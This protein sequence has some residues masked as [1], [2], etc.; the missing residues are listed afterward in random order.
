MNILNTL[1]NF[2]YFP[3]ILNLARTQRKGMSFESYSHLNIS[4]KY[5]TFLVHGLKYFVILNAHFA[6]HSN[7][8]DISPKYLW[9]E[10]HNHCKCQH[11]LFEKECRGHRHRELE[12]VNCN[13]R[14]FTKAKDRKKSIGI[15]LLCQDCTVSYLNFAIDSAL[16]RASKKL[17]DIE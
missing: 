13:V 5:P 2:G 3:E 11:C 12:P 7:I 4:G 6:G 9:W 10:A 16:E 17:F 14:T 15:F 8:S 1:K